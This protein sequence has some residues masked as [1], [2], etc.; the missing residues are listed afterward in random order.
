MLNP[1]ENVWDKLKSFFYEYKARASI[2]EI[3]DFIIDYFNH[4]NS[5]KVETRSLVD[6]RSYY[7]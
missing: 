7:K 4:M 3:K 1:Q 2:N 5:N 6:G